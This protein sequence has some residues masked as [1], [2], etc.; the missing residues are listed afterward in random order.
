[1]QNNASKIACNWWLLLLLGV[2]IVLYFCTIEKS[3]DGALSRVEDRIVWSFR[4]VVDDST[5]MRRH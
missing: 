1:M 5:L 4:L 3:F 2:I